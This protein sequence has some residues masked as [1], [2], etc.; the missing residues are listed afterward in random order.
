MGIAKTAYRNIYL[1]REIKASIYKLLAS[2]QS[3]LH[4]LL[5]YDLQYLSQHGFSE[6]LVKCFLCLTLAFSI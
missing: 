4:R 6:A 2:L 1:H 3:C 5:C